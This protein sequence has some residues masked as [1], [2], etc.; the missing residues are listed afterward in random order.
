MIWARRSLGKWVA[1]ALESRGEVR[2][3]RG[4]GE[5]KG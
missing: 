1:E 2:R 4:Y 3:G 5:D